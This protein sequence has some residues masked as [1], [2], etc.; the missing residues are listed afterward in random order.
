MS[1]SSNDPR[2]FIQSLIR[3]GLWD[4]ALEMASK[5]ARLEPGQ[6]AAWNEV[7]L[8]E[9]QRKGYAAAA[10][11][12]ARAVDLDPRSPI[13]RHHLGTA[14]FYLRRFDDAENE[15]RAALEIAPSQAN[16]R[17]KLAE[18]FARRKAW[19]E[20]LAH[21]ETLV[22][23]FPNDASSWNDYGVALFQAGRLEASRDAL[24]KATELDA[25]PPQP[26]FNLGTTLLALHDAPGALRC[27]QTAVSLRPDY[28]K[29]HFRLAELLARLGQ[30]DAA[31]DHYRQAGRF[32]TRDAESLSRAG[33][34]LID[35]DRLAEAA[36]CF[37]EALRRKPEQVR[38]AVNL[39]SVLCQT[40]RDGEA[41]PVLQDACAK[42][43]ELPEAHNN[44]G[45][46][47]FNL[48]RYEEA[49]ACYDRAIAL[50]PEHGKA[51]HNRG[52]ALAHAGRIDEAEAA[53]HQALKISPDYTLSKFEI[54]TLQ[55]LR[56]RW[57]EGL[58]AY[59]TRF[60]VPNGKKC[61]R[62]FSWTPWSGESLVGRSILLWAEQGLGDTI[63]FIRFAPYVQ[64]L[65]AQVV[66]EVQP[67]LIPLMR[68]VAGVD[69]WVARGA[70]LPPTDFHAPLLS[71]PRLLKLR[72]D[73]MPRP[74]PYLDADARLVN[75][76]RERLA[77]LDGLRVGVV[78][79]G[80]PTYLADSLRSIPLREFEP[81]ARV[82][83]VHLISLQQ[84]VGLDQLAEVAGRFPVTTLGKDVDVST[85]AFLDTAA[86]MRNLDLIV[87]ADTSSLHLA[88][89]LGC[90]AW[91]ALTFFHEWRWL[92]NRDDAIW[93]P[94]VRLFRQKQP[95]QW[96]DVFDAMAGELRAMAPAKR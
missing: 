43:P 56:G 4:E 82:P 36:D 3:Q 49:L 93:Y 60:E 71:L 33:E 64:M 21:H 79:Q 85:G 54:A 50:R 24:R 26:H 55:L 67:K 61:R 23:Q 77:H 2:P 73:R 83:G 96:R 25:S 69:E 41:L 6:A 32:E 28:A 27:Y 44:L 22:A 94:A 76:W 57:D 92:M 39:G 8:I 75:V 65:G 48:G 47:Y 16:S 18:L 68:H 52:R 72:P 29:A 66:V 5:W 81:L 51:W 42:A 38:T 46:A 10:E 40:G 78:W 1:S 95:G 19:P 63:Q 62:P 70:P 86:I 11:V 12:F 59:E 7:G 35:A 87:S 45:I 9:L 31:I 80:S 20:C 91:A 58:D 14:W 30:R 53:F 15:Y 34:L 17:R 74:T 13:Y 89:A 84:F 90:R 37:R 88:G